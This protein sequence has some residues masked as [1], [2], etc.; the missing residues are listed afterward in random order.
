MSKTIRVS[1]GLAVLA[2]AAIS[3][4]LALRASYVATLPIPFLEDEVNLIRPALALT[5]T[6]ADF[7]DAILPIPLGRP[8]PHEMIGVAY[9]EL[10]RA[11]LTSSSSSGWMKV[12][13]TERY[14]SSSSPRTR[15]PS[16]S[17]RSSIAWSVRSSGLL[18]QTSPSCQINSGLLPPSAGKVISSSSPRGVA[19]RSLLGATAASTS[20]RA[21][22]TCRRARLRRI[23]TSGAGPLSRLP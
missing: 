8:D 13:F 21:I 14:V 4:G 16:A 11:S 15:A 6:S 20:L 10:L 7:A 19:T 17:A 2:A 9:L 12:S 1:A 18:V 5:G 23:V 3:A 22:G